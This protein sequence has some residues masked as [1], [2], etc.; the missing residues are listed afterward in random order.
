M[1]HAAAPSDS[2]PDPVIDLADVDGSTASG[3]LE[4][5]G[6]SGISL[7]IDQGEF[8][9]VI[10]PSGSGK[11]TL[12]HILGCLDVPTSGRFLL[13]GH[14]ISGLDESQLWSARPPHRLI[15]SSSTS[16]PTCPA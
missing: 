3:G 7:T 11:S 13:S 9:A 2:V 5:A 10:G 15:S 14:D 12:M 4:V 1:H 16:S 6:Y 8:V